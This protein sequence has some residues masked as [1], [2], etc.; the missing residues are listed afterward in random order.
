MGEGV[1]P[2]SHYVA[3]QLFVIATYGVV[4]QLGVVLLKDRVQ[5]LR[6]HL[7]VGGTVCVSGIYLGWN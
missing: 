5:A 6:R 7:I 1:F 2:L 3:A 4:Y